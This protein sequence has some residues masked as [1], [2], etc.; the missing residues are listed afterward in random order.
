MI[1]EAIKNK[2]KTKK[3]EPGKI[4]ILRK[5]SWFYFFE[6]TFLPE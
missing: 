5:V 6:L 4:I 3:I 2:T 1:K